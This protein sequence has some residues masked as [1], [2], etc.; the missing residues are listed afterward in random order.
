MLSPDK[1]LRS[2]PN[3]ERLYS[4][5]PIAQM[6]VLGDAFQVPLILEIIKTMIERMN[7]IP[8]MI[9]ILSPCFRSLS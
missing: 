1:K 4:L 7:S 3:D 6:R 5:A 2:E 9:I 8:E